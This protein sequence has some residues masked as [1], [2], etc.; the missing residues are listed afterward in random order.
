MVK[1]M[2]MDED[3]FWP[4]TY[5]TKALDGTI[6]YDLNLQ[7]ALVWAQQLTINGRV[8]EQRDERRGEVGDP[9]K[10]AVRENRGCLVFALA[11]A[12]RTLQKRP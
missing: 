2:A 9:S 11:A 5:I 1:C 7:H 8:E 6:G 12:S 3:F 10:L 4:Q